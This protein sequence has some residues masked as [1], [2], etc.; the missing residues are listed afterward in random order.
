MEIM[1][2]GKKYTKVLIFSTGAGAP[3]V[4]SES[5]LQLQVFT[6]QESLIDLFDKKMHII[7]TYLHTGSLYIQ[8]ISSKTLARNGMWG[9]RHSPPEPEERPT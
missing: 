7:G 8:Y 3:L 9:P 5:F 2:I 1:H 6:L 4:L